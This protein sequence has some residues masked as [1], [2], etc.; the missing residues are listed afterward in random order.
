MSKTKK[1]FREKTTQTFDAEDFDIH[2]VSHSIREKV[3]PLARGEKLAKISKDLRWLKGQV[4]ESH[5]KQKRSILITIF[6]N[7]LIPGLGNAYVHGS[8]FSV[9]ILALSMLVMFT[10]LSPVF[11]II[12]VLNATQFIQPTS[13]AVA[14]IALFVP[15]NVVVNNQVTLVGPTFSVL[16][17][18][19]IL[20]WVHIIYLFVHRE[21]HV[22]WQL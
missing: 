18:P 2:G 14:Q 16:V 20:S 3:L 10:T 5:V 13:G 17:V 15:A 6:S 1:R 7:I 11:P 22:D 9:S 19:L 12:Q 4:K 21:E 8:A